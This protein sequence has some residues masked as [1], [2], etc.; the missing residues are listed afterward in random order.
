MMITLISRQGS[1][2]PT[3]LPN[4]SRFLPRINLYHLN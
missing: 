3:R 1:R 4:Q 2:H